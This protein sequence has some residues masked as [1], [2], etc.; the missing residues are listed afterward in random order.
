MEGH[1]AAPTKHQLHRDII[2]DVLR[3]RQLTP[4]PHPVFIHPGKT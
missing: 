3:A 4:I 2:V 1:K